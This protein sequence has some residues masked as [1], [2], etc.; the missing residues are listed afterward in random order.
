MHKLPWTLLKKKIKI[1][2]KIKISLNLAVTN[3]LRYTQPRKCPSGNSSV[4]YLV[5]LRNWSDFNDNPQLDETRL[6]LSSAT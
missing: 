1:K 6:K 4:E 3:K 5:K 2:I